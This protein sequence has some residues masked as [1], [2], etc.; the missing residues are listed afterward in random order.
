ML[1]YTGSTT[2]H[3]LW[4]ARQVCAKGTASVL[5]YLQSMGELHMESA[6]RGGGGLATRRL[7]G[8]SASGSD[9]EEPHRCNECLRLTGEV[10]DL[11]T[12]VLH[13]C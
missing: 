4:A 13:P 3:T 11:N 7:S 12:Q 2:P 5:A 10:D 8:G 6:M 1:C 9:T